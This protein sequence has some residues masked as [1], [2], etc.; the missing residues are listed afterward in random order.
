MRKEGGI[1]VKNCCSR[2]QNTTVESYFCIYGKAVNHKESHKDLTEGR[3][4]ISFG[5]ANGDDCAPGQTER[6]KHEPNYRIFDTDYENYSIVYWCKERSDGQSVDA[7]WLLSRTPQINPD[8]EEKVNY[9][10][11]TYFDRSALTIV[12][13]D[14]QM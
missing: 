8:V 11:D 9:Y 13:Q 6:A 2:L 10:I 1:K 7:F 14:R 4:D 5:I 12:K 3:L